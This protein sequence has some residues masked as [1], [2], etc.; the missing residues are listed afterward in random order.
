[1]DRPS[2]I[3]LISLQ[4]KTTGWNNPMSFRRSL[5]LIARERLSIRIRRLIL[6][7]ILKSRASSRRLNLLQQCWISTASQGLQTSLTSLLLCLKVERLSHMIKTPR[8]VPDRSRKTAVALS[9]TFFNRSL[10]RR[11][12]RK[13]SL[14]QRLRSWRSNQTISRPKELRYWTQPLKTPWFITMLLRATN[15]SHLQVLELRK[16]SLSYSINNKQ[17]SL[18][19]SQPSV[20]AHLKSLMRVHQ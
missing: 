11:R 14:W 6:P 5:H 2:M 17:E 18:R 9:F 8:D 4:F 20:E 12:E 1:M 3:A 7:S 19:E 16:R 15:S 13:I 10:C